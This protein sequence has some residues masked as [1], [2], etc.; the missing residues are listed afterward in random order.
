MTP[1]IDKPAPPPTTPM[2]SDASV[3]TARYNERTRG[4]GAITNNL[5]GAFA[6]RAP[7]AKTVTTGGGV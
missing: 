5:S 6:K 1:K 2:R 3:I 4:L 7:T